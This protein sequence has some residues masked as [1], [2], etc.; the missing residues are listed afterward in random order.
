VTAYEGTQAFDLTRAPFQ[1]RADADSYQVAEEIAACFEVVAGLSAKLTR[2]AHAAMEVIG[3]AEDAPLARAAATLAAEIDAGVGDGRANPYHNSQH[4]CEVLL[5]TLYLT[6]QASMPPLV[7]AR[8]VAAALAHD[9]HHDGRTSIGNPFRLERLA[10][11]AAL[12]YFDAAGVAKEEQA[13]ISTLIL[14][15]ETTVGVP[16]ARKCHEHFTRGATKPALP[17][18]EMHLAPLAEDASLAEQAVLLAEA[19]LLPSVGL[20]VYYGE[21]TQANLS[22]EWG[23]PMTAVDKLFFLERI[24]VEFQVGRFFSPNLQRLKEAMQRKAE[25]IKR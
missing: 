6:A 5:S 11:Q 22:K 20:T 16:F 24:F 15:T 19:D 8:L 1:L 23:R 2:A 17:E 14:S 18:A 3:L 21:L 12:P 10:A 9:F 13:C 7:R 25:A 4:Y